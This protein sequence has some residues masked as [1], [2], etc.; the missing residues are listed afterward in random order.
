M[1]TYVMDTSVKQIKQ[2]TSKHDFNILIT[3]AANGSE[4]DIAIFAI[5]SIN[6]D[7]RDK[8]NIYN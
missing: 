2:A 1:G 5:Q 7:L 4:T 6:S 8:N 3:S